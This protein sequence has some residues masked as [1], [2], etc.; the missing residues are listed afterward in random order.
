MEVLGFRGFKTL[1]T[2]GFSVPNGE[3]GSGLTVITGPNNAGKSSILE[4]E[5]PSNS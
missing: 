1:G 2:I 4:F 5:V 3:I